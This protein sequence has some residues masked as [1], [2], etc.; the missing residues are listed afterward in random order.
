MAKRKKTVR[1]NKRQERGITN[2]PSRSRLLL[3]KSVPHPVEDNRL[4][5]PLPSPMRLPVT[6]RGH[7]AILPSMPSRQ[8]VTAPLHNVAAMR[9]ALLCVRRKVRREV[10][11]A[12]NKVGAGARAR[13]R[14]TDRS[15]IKCS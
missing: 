7:V 12:Q 10:L 9:S 11:M 4:F 2:T 15:N 8:Y 5:T 6:V 1:T 13:R 3:T 14:F